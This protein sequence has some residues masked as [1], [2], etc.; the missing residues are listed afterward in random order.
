[1]YKFA[2]KFTAV[3]LAGVMT[4]NAAAASA[5]APA[6]SETPPL[7]EIVLT[8]EDARYF[9]G[10]SPKFRQKLRE[11]FVS[12]LE[13][14][15]YEQGLRFFKYMELENEEEVE[16][17][18]FSEEELELLKSGEDA[19]LSVTAPRTTEKYSFLPETVPEDYDC[20]SFVIVLDDGE[21]ITQDYH[22]NDSPYTLGKLMWD[23]KI[24]DPQ[25]IGFIYVQM[26]YF[27]FEPS[28]GGISAIPNKCGWN[29]IG[30]KRYYLRDS[31]TLA[32]SPTTIDGI[33]Y[34]FDEN[35]VCLGRYTGYS[36]SSKGRRYWKNG[37][38]L[39]NK[40]IKVKGERKYYADENGYFVTGTREIGGKTFVFGESG[41]LEK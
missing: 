28:R 11:M 22:L 23:C 3:I 20:F 36:N 34:A 26:G 39:K 16:H 19:L 5:D 30:G 29:E 14:D 8:P 40:W 10:E 27:Y 32:K 7:P 15:G 17:L 1:M 41:A 12:I 31:G 2:K 6:S 33:R 25:R 37:E 21:E 24:S 13:T 38:L 18:Y 35:G 4:V 9:A